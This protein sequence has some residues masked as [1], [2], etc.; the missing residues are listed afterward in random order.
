MKNVTQHIGNLVILRRLPTSK[1]GNPRYLIMVDGFTCR[2]QVDSMHAYDIPNLEGKRVKVT[3]GTHYGV[4][5][6]NSLTKA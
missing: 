3:I 2:T 1:L 5:T 6:L 4:A